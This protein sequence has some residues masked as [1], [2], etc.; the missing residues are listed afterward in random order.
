MFDYKYGQPTDRLKLKPESLFRRLRSPSAPP[1]PVLT[2][3][4]PYIS[5]LELVK[6]FLSVSHQWYQTIE[7]P[8]IWQLQTQ[9]LTHNASGLYDSQANKVK[10]AYKRLLQVSKH[11][12]IETESAANGLKI[13]DFDE[14]HVENACWKFVYWYI[15]V[16]TCLECGQPE[17][18]MRFTQ[19]L[20]RALCG[21]CRKLDKYQMIDHNAALKEFGITKKDLNRYQI[22]GLR[23]AD[24][25]NEGKKMFVYYK[26]DINRLILLK[27]REEKYSKPPVTKENKREKGVE[28]RKKLLLDSL[29]TLDITDMTFIADLVDKTESW[30]REYI[31]GTVKISPK[32]LVTKVENAYKKWVSDK[33]NGSNRRSRGFEGNI[34]SINVKRMQTRPTPCVPVTKQRKLTEED[35]AYRRQELMDRLSRMGVTEDQVEFEDPDEEAYKYVHGE[36]TEIGPVA[37]AIWRKLRPGLIP[38]AL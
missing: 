29:N 3:V 15:L 33:K 9:S 17:G 6:S 28:V 1:D 36:R 32:K 27:S 31:E 24:P 25:L 10:S 23:V 20:R 19:L 30:G 22:D 11:A 4:F 18:K 5:G 35:Y 2:Q 12:Q 26:T 16:K 14:K 8:Q 38:G 21:N 13:T 34:T 37:G 7:Q